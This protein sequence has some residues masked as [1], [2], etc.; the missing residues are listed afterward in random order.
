LYTKFNYNY[1]QLP[2]ELYSVVLSYPSIRFK[3][4]FSEEQ[5]LQQVLEMDHVLS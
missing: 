1:F 2:C 4:S 3:E 5:G